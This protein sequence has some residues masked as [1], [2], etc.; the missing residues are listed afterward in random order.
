MDGGICHRKRRETASLQMEKNEGW[1][2]GVRV[3]CEG[4]GNRLSCRR[5]GLFGG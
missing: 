3:A 2:V 5:C 1:V 4:V